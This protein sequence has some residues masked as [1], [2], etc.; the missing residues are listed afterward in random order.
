MKTTLPIKIS[1]EDLYNNG[2]EPERGEKIYKTNY[3]NYSETYSTVLG[4]HT[5]SCIV[6]HDKICGKYY[7][8]PTNINGRNLEKYKDKKSGYYNKVFIAHPRK[9]YIS[10]WIKDCYILRNV[11]I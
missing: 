5:S 7:G 11:E 9:K 1:L 6:N 2:M 4:S 8:N 3:Y 10:L